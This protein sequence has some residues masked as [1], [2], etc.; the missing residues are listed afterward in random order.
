MKKGTIIALVVA[1]LLIIAG[2]TIL[3][4][5]LSFA[6]NSTRESSLTE[7]NVPVRESFESILIDTQDCGVEFVPYNGAADAHIVIRQRED[8]SHQILVADGTLRIEMRDDRDWTDYVGIFPAIESMEMKIYLPEKQYESLV[9]YTDTGDVKVPGELSVKEATIRTDTGD[10]YYF[11][12]TAASL[13]CMSS[14][15]DI[16]VRGGAPALMKLQTNTGD[17]NLQ[18]V[19]GTEIYL[20]NDTGETEME[21]VAAKML[22]CSSDTGDVELEKV[23]VEDYLQVFTTTGDVGIENSDAGTVNIETDTGDVSGNFLT[24]KWFQARSDTGRVSVPNTREGGECRI[25]TD[26]GDISF[27]YDGSQKIR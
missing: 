21:N 22:S 2:G 11:G 7:H 13:D 23:L 6:G 16:S 25:E 18:G 17:L 12:N 15:G 24:S 8:V 14:T 1:I 26:T 19:S 3:M 10:V 27:F 9:V 4:L 5:G 20:E